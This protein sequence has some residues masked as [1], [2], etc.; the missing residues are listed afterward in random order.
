MEALVSGAGR[1]QAGAD[2]EKRAAQ[3]LADLQGLLRFPMAKGRAIK[4]VSLTAGRQ[5]IAHGLRRNLEG[6]L[7]TRNSVAT[8]E[9]YEVP[10]EDGDYDATRHLKLDV[11]TACTVDLW[12]W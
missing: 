11:L 5:L 4:G 10:P 2:E 3:Q 7:V 12:V 8:F 6:W 9:G 1:D